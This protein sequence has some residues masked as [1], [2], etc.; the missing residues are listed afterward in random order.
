VQLDIDT[1]FWCLIVYHRTRYRHIFLMIHR[2]L[3]TF[4]NM[5]LNILKTP[6]EKQLSKWSKEPTH[7]SKSIYSLLF[8]LYSFFSFVYCLNLCFC[9]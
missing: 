4:L 5:L 3:Y 8:F 7:I 9:I 1:Y 2:I 6:K